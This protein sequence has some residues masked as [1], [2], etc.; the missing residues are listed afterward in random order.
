M[1]TSNSSKEDSVVS[2]AT[3]HYMKD[4][5]LPQQ[6]REMMQLD[7]SELHYTQSIPGTEKSE[8]VEDK[9]FCNPLTANNH[10]NKKGNWEMPL[11]FKTANV[12]LPSN[13][14]Q[15]LKNCSESSGNSLKNSKTLKHYTEFLQKIFDKNRTSPVP[16]EEL[17]TSA[18]QGPDMMNS[19]LGVLSR[20]RKKKLY[21]SNVTL[22]SCSTV[23]CQPGSQRLSKISVV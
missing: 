19:L 4:V 14:D 16:P 10:K 6:V 15:C 17:K 8:A 22:N 5:T 13:H 12:T 9:C 20:F 1:P 3:K 23:F 2:F 21:S 7:Y 18:L 11:P